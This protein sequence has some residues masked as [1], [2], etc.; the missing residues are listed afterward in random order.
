MVNEILEDEPEDGLRPFVFLIV[1]VLDAEEANNIETAKVFVN[2]NPRKICKS[3]THEKSQSNRRWSVPKP[4]PL[5]C[6]FDDVS[7]KRI[8]SHLSHST[9]VLQTEAEMS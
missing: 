9:K 5:H 4:N 8:V 2:P 3:K 1:N 6:D 7:L